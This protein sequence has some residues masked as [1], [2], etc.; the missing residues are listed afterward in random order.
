MVL[1]ATWYSRTRSATLSQTAFH[2]PGLAVGIVVAAISAFIFLGG[3]KYI[4]SV[5][6]KVVPVMAVLYVLGSLIVLVVNWRNLGTA[7]AQIF[8][9]AF[10]PQAMAGGVAGV[11]VREA[12]RFGVARGLFSN[13]AG[14]GS[15]PHAHALAKVEHPCDQGVVA[16]IGVFIDTFVVLT[17]TA[18]V[19]PLHRLHLPHGRKRRPADRR[20]SRTGGLQLCLRR[21]RQRVHRAIC[22]LFFAFSTIIGWYFFGETN[23]KYL[24]GKKAVPVYAALVIVFVV[25]GSLMKVDLVW[26]LS[27][28]FNSLMVLPNLI[29]VLAL[30]AVVVKLSKEHDVLAKARKI[31]EN[32]RPRRTG[33]TDSAVFR[34][35]SAAA[36]L[37]RRARAETP[38]PPR[39]GRESRRTKRTT[40]AFSPSSSATRQSRACCRSERQAGVDVN[41]SAETTRTGL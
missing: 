40:N 22:M 29:G 37:A 4:V 7:F 27:D 35:R 24:F 34:P 26:A 14:M 41:R 8:V 19:I 23:V 3:K 25:P 20:S 16:M 39:T 17:M 30:T 6:E 28:M 36:D 1:W 15:T 9:L 2:V 12:I 5:T 32:Q 21:I 18:L 11:T 13:E 31:T 33:R 10:D 38:S